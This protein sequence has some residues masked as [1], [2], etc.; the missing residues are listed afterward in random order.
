LL[1]FT[2][3]REAAFS[4][5]LRIRGGPGQRWKGPLMTS[6][7]STD[8]DKTFYQVQEEDMR[9]TRGYFLDYSMTDLTENAREDS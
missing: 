8:R 7:Y 1:V 6:P 2:G 4:G 5:G 9:A 3:E